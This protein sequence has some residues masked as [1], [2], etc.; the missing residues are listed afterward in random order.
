MREA[1]ARARARA[2]TRARRASSRRRRARERIGEP[3]GRLGRA[4]DSRRRNFFSGRPSGRPRAGGFASATRASPRDRCADAE[5]D[6]RHGCGASR[7]AIG[8]ADGAR[9][10]KRRERRRLARAAHGVSA[11][12]AR[13]NLRAAAAG[14]TDSSQTTSAPKEQPP[15]KLSGKRTAACV[16]HLESDRRRVRLGRRQRSAEGITLSGARDRWGAIPGRLWPGRSAH[17]TSNDR[18]RSAT[19]PE[20]ARDFASR[21]IGPS[22]DEVRRHARRRRRR[23]A[24]TSSIARDA[25][26]GD[27]P[28]RRRCAIGAG[29]VR[30]R[31]ARAAARAREREPGAH[32]ADRPGLPRH[33]HAAGHPAQHA[34]EPGVVHGVHAVPARDQP[35][36]ARGA[37][38]LP[39]DGHRSH[40]ARHRERVAAR[41]GDRGGRSDGAGAARR[42]K[43][44]ATAFFVDARCHPQTIAVVR[45]R[46]EP[47]GWTSSS[48][49]PTRDLDPKAVFGALVQYPGTHGRVRDLARGRSRA[50]TRGRR[51]RRR[52]G[53][54]ARAPLLTPPGELGADIA[55]GS[56]Q[57]FGVPMGFGGPHAGYMA[58]RDAF[59]R[60]IPGRLIGVSVD[61]H[62]QPAYRLALQTREQHIRREKAT[63]NIC[64]AQVLLAVIASMYAVYHGPEGLRAIARDVHRRTASLAAGLRKLGRRAAS[65]AFFDTRHGATPARSATRS[66]GAR[67]ACGINLR[68]STTTASA[69][70][71]TRPRRPRWSRPCGARS[72]AQLRFADVEAARGDRAARRRCA[73]AAR[74]SRTRLPPLPLRDRDA[75]LPAPARRP[76]LALDRA[77]IPLGSCTMKLNATSEMI[78][79]TWPE[80][81]ALHPFA[82]ADQA[83][84]YARAVRRPRALA[85][86]DHRLR[87]GLAAA[88]RRRAGRVRRPARDP[89]VPRE[90]RRGAAHRVP[91]PVLRAR[92]QPRDRAQMAGM[93]RG[94]R[95]LRRRRQRR[96]RRPA[97]EGRA[98]RGEARRADGHLSVDARRVR[99][100]H[101]RDLRRSS[102]ST[103]ARC[104]STARTSTRRSASRGRAS[105]AP[106]SRTSTC[107]RRSA[108]R[109]AAAA[110]AWARSACEAHLAPFLPGH[111]LRRRRPAPVGP[112]SAAPW[113]SASILPISWMYILMMGGAGLTDATAG[114][115]PQR[116]LHRDAARPALPGAL[117]R[118]KRARRARVHPRRARAQGIGGV[119]VDDI[120]KRLIDYGFHAPTM[121]FPVP[122]TLM[123][124]PTE[125]EAKVELDRFCDAMIAIREEIAEVETRPLRDR[126]TT[127]CGRAAHGARPGRRRSG[128]ARTR[129]RRRVPR[130]ARRA[131]Q[132]LGPVNRVDNVYGDRNLICSAR[133]RTSTEDSEA[134]MDR[135]MSRVRAP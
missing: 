26:R 5:R 90:P 54:P 129:A 122:G 37:A 21:H 130:R 30:G 134:E 15:R 32:L 69:S 119:K 11:N 110:R 74:S 35:G 132:V 59:K 46:A 135:E 52:R 107:T 118:T 95:R 103:A 123:I 68:A 28:A 105:S 53:R 79:V 16:R 40:R 133:R 51:D 101:R 113:G 7:A 12:G 64:T 124:E 100:A 78:P 106:T 29:P 94:R 125:S 10:S 63:S 57:R 85:R 102:T 73:A 23:R 116:E 24:S 126:A 108:S 2:A 128:T 6:R 80:F 112:V 127:R 55:I 22:P 44:K 82:P 65:D 14:E 77:M 36:P 131:G 71:S 92:H 45:T 8:D 109:T 70:R 25:A 18:I 66:C 42:R 20:L 41:R 31:S 19:H 104:T 83:R 34:R 33:D 67:S 43:S 1:I 115:D 58:M 86:R 81:G 3:E 38:E 50:L 17:P 88:E 48:A 117:H 98:A 120:A 9:R 72:A 111:P 121:S 93:R 76:D 97:R 13:G 62:G 91:D 4:A 60:S 49:I 84:G 114:R 47:L 27:P 39:D 87:R 89:R 61:A 56:T 75:A 96:R 99:G